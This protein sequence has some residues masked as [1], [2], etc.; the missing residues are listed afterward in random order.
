[1]RHLTGRYIYSNNDWGTMQR[2]HA[3][4]SELLGRCPHT[5]EHA[6][7]LARIVMKLFDRGLRD[8]EVLAWVAANQETVISDFASERDGSE[9]S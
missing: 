5:H 1:M 9:A 3:K 6:N 4:A 7:R 8:A 2:A